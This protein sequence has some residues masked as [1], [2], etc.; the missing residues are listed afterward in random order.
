MY[1]GAGRS[2]L[3]LSAG[4]AIFPSARRNDASDTALAAFIDLDGS[5]NDAIR[6]LKWPQ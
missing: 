5:V 6:S 4:S 1:I 3:R 2:G